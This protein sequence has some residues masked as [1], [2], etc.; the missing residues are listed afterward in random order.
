MVAQRFHDL[1]IGK[2]SSLGRFSTRI[3]RTPS[4]G[5]H[6]GIFDTDHAAAHNDQG[7][8]Q[9][10][11][12]QHLVAVDDAAAIDRNFGR[13]GWLGA[14]GQDISPLRKPSSRSHW[15]LSRAWHL[16]SSRAEEHVDAIARQL[17]L[18]YVHF[19]LDDV[20]HAKSKIGHVI[21]SFT[22]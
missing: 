20:L 16:R 11:K 1:L 14:G 10:R 8:R 6:A 15:S 18:D 4:G 13:A 7:F 9:L 5:E 12:Q 17:R 19:G 22:R 3:T 21:F 2:P